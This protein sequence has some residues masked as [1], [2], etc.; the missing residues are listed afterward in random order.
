M[1]KY[2][3]HKIENLI[4]I[5]KI[6]AVHE[7]SFSKEFVFPEESHDFWEI[8]YVGKNYVFVPTEG[9]DILVKEGEALFHKPCEKHAFKAN[10]KTSSEVIIIS[11]ECKSPAMRFFEN[12]KIFV[13]SEFQKYFYSVAMEARKTF[14]VKTS[15]PESKK[16]ELLSMP[17]LG[18]M[19]LIK[20]N[21]ECLLITLMRDETEKDGENPVFLNDRDYEGKIA[22]SIKEYLLKNLYESVSIDDVCRELNYSKSYVFKEFR[23]A[24]NKSVM[25]Y[26]RDLKT[27]KAK[28]LLTCTSMS[29]SEISEKL[30]FD[31]PN[32][33]S[34]TFKKSVGVTPLKYRKTQKGG[35][36]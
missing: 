9:S 24:F 14:D 7:F 33:F 1:K 30:N 34:K 11:F 18:G 21:L 26:Y 10:G 27:E 5:N 12:K 17:T 22:A 20:N 28:E 16:L 36:I 19:Q 6:I 25:A 31:T 32:Y 23:L 29:V 2:F 8:L 15:A 4:T 3:R 13:R 35:I